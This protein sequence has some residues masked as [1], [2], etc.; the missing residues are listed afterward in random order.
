MMI[1]HER[2]VALY[3]Y[4]CTKLR[5]H[6]GCPLPGIKSDITTRVHSCLFIFLE[7]TEVTDT[8]D[9]APKNAA[10]TNM[11]T[12]IMASKNTAPEVIAPEATVVESAS[13]ERIR[14]GLWPRC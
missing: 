10:I 13:M 6:G 3:E 8:E 2:E 14:W 5:L 9:M 12:E 11:V 4:I 1:I 7:A